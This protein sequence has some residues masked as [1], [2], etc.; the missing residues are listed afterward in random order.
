VVAATA[1]PAL[2]A[3]DLQAVEVWSKS[4]SKEGHFILRPKVFSLRLPSYCSGVNETE[5]YALPPCVLQAVP[6]WSKSVN[7]EG[8][9]TVE[10]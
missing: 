9:F 6:V 7:N 1:D 4:V 3:R 8:H 2:S 10:A 5:Q